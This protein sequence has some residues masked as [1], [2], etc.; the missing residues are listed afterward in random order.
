[1]YFDQKNF[2]TRMNHYILGLESKR[3]KTKG[4]K[5]FIIL[6]CKKCINTFL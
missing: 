5:T 3:T 6:F 4:L 2:K 1:M